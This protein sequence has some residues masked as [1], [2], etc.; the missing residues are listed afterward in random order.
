[1]S[2]QI[3]IVKKDMPDVF[4]NNLSNYDSTLS[5]S[6]N[7]VES[8]SLDSFS[9]N[10]QNKIKISEE[11]QELMQSDEM[12]KMYVKSKILLNNV[13]NGVVTKDIFKESYFDGTLN[14]VAGYERF[15]SYINTDVVQ[16][17]DLE[18]YVPQGLC[19]VDG[20]TLISCYDDSGKS[21]YE[22]GEPVIQ[23]IN[24]KGEKKIVKLDLPVDTHVGGMAYD[25]I[26]N[27]IWVTGAN[28]EVGVYSY[29]SIMNNNGGIVKSINSFDTGLINEDKKKA[30][31]YMTYYNGK[32]YVGTFNENSRG[33]V[34]EFSINNDGVS[35]SDTGKSFT[36]P[37]KTQGI[38]FYEKEGKTYMAQSRSY[39]RQ[40]SSNVRIFEYANNKDSYLVDDAI[41]DMKVPP[42]S[43]QINFTEDGNLQLVFESEAHKYKEVKNK[44]GEVASVS[45]PSVVTLETSSCLN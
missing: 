14:L 44:S 8:I 30:A 22:A 7:N 36:V 32:I 20:C 5:G 16:M 45:I 2:K 39:G 12:C 4:N 24:P 31:S 3:S 25:S 26:N 40:K 23:I 11:V 9:T 19:T 15:L 37:R 21:G 28:G 38:S 1:M 6:S 29:D 18:N 10:Q 42:L 43:E 13:P 34:K 35:I 27:N 17:G 41:F 33:M